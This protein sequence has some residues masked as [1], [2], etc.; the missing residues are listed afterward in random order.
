[1]NL[2]ILVHVIKSIEYFS[3]YEHDYFFGELARNSL[4]HGA[5]IAS[6]H[7]L[8]NQIELVYTIFVPFVRLVDAE[9]ILLTF[10]CHVLKS[11]LSQSVLQVRI[12]GRRYLFHG[13][14]LF[15]PVVLHEVYRAEATLAQFLNLSEALV[16]V[17]SL[18]LVADL[19]HALVQV[20]FVKHGLEALSCY[21]VYSH[22]ELERTL[23]HFMRL[24]FE[25]TDVAFPFLRKTYEA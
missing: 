11:D 7:P 14:V 9:N 2:L 4:Q 20:C 25:L 16:G 15:G 18:N 22:E 8:H 17:F 10:T 12:I 5:E 24:Y 19:A 3:Q 6:I 1:M 23:G 21:I 13:E